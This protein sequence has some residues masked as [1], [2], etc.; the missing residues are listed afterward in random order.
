ME[1]LRHFLACELVI[2]GRL[3]ICTNST[4]QDDSFGRPENEKVRFL[5]RHGIWQ[6]PY[7]A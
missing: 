7:P 6:I 5:D 1:D 4:G 2:H 3:Q